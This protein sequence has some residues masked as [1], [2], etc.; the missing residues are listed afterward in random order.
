MVSAGGVATTNGTPSSSANA[1]GAPPGLSLGVG[2]RVRTIRVNA[3]D[4]QFTP[5][6]HVFFSSLVPLAD[7]TNEIRVAA[8]DLTGKRTERILHIERKRPAIETTQLP[9][10]TTYLENPAV[11]QLRELKIE[12]LT[13]LQ[14]FDALRRLKDAADAAETPPSA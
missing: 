1:D 11:D 2:T 6:R 4:L 10:F 9:L 13:P 7:G 14:A 8:T 5:G 12:S 3:K